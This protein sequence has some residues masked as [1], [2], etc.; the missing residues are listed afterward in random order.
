LLKTRLQGIWEHDF[1]LFPQ[2]KCAEVFTLSDD[3]ILSFLRYAPVMSSFR[4][5]ILW[6]IVTSSDNLNNVS[7]Q[8]ALTRNESLTE[9]LQEIIIR[10][11]YRLKMESIRFL[12][13]KVPNLILLGDTSSWGVE[14]REVE[15]IKTELKSMNSK[16]V[17]TEM[18]ASPEELKNEHIF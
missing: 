7:L 12:I 17:I 11:A 15:M 14:E 10:P 2:L 1:E 3:T 4:A 5:A 9:N 8:N 18:S 13:E 6:G 16:I